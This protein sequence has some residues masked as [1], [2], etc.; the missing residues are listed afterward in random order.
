M[1]NVKRTMQNLEVIK[2]DVVRNLILVKGAVPGHKGSKVIVQFAVKHD[3]NGLDLKLHSPNEE[4]EPQLNK[5]NETN[6]N[7]TG[8]EM[9]PEAPAAEE[10]TTEAP[11]AEEAATSK[12]TN[13]DDSEESK[14]E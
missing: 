6:N 10:A 7:E 2:I 14:K 5:D 13:I 12:T 11:A 8:A 3:H 4:Q 9:K 1:G